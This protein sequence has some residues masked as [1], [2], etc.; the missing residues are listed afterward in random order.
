M[1]DWTPEA[2]KALR[3]RF[4]LT[5]TELAEMLGVSSLYVS[6]LERNAKTPSKTLEL[7]LHYVEKELH[8]IETEN[9]NEKGGTHGKKKGRR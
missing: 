5:Q 6:L 1:S 2:I 8:Q 7:L 4:R 9:E 3:K